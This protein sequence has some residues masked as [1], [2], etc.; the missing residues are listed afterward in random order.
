M[1]LAW[2]LRGAVFC[3]V[4]VTALLPCFAQQ[5]RGDSTAPPS[6]VPTPDATKDPRAQI[7]ELLQQA[8]DQINVKVQFQKAAELAQ[9]ALDLSLNAGDKVR[10]STAMVYLS[11]AYGYGGR[12]AEAYDVT[13]KLVI[14]ARETGDRRTLEQALNT[15]GS[16]AGGFG[17]YEESLNYFQECLSVARDSKDTTM[18]YMSLLNIGEAYVRSGE[19]ERAE[20]PL[21]ESLRLA[22]QLKT[23]DPKTISKSKKGMEMALLNL[24]GMEA[25]RHRYRPAL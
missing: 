19:P 24:G 11:A 18:E 1:T 25:E 5:Q 20:A 22:G 6:S 13:Q 21:L 2:K 17:R 7:D 15:A 14:L 3:A 16:V 9:Q 8:Y 10:A 12:L 23:D 4:L